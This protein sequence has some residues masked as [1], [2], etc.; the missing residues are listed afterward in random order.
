MGRGAICLWEGSCPVGCVDTVIKNICP[1]KDPKSYDIIKRDCF[2]NKEKW[3][4]GVNV[5]F[6]SSIIK[7]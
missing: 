6:L 7:G 2:T 5:P 3:M 1:V 4:N